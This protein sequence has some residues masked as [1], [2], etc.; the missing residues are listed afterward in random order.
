[1]KKL[2]ILGSTGSIGK[3]TLDVIENN[4]MFS[5]VAM[6]ANTNYKL[7]CTQVNK[8]KPKY[9][10]I[11][12]KKG[13]DYLNLN[14]NYSVKIFHGENAIK[15]MC[16]EAE[17][18]ILV[19]AVTGTSTLETT[20]I[21]LKSGKRVAIAN[22]EILVTSGKIINDLVKKYKSELIPIDS[23]HSAIFQALQCG[24]KDEVNRIILTASGGAFRNYSYDELKNVTL[25]DALKHPNWNM[26]KKITIDSATLIN[27]GL[28]II[29][30]R[31]LFDYDYDKIDVIMHPESIIHSMVEYKD[32][33][34]IAQLG[35]PDM[36][37][38]IQYALTHP[39]RISNNSVKSLN[40]LEYNLLTFKKINK[41]IFKGIDFAYYAGKTG[42]TMPLCLNTANDLAVNYFV[43]QK[44]KF[45]DIYKIIEYA[46]ETHNLVE[47]SCV[48]DIVEVEKYEK[49][50]I[51]S[52]IEL[53][54]K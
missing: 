40:L 13:Y 52:Y 12:T 33:S 21:A 5:I 53:N 54:Y 3:N 7:F 28:E 36:R 29:E 14:I 15:E 31:Y 45:L 17:Y 2:V 46:M 8:Y 1:M 4:S 41:D 27:K 35:T 22:K 26:G 11:G 19:N 30:A 47:T 16:N 24:E 44:I 50:R 6:S 34:I 37:I 48:K 9:I 20:V 18:D 25:E 43:K 38:P 39:Y 32:N 49:N 10:A 42:K 51:N 23:E